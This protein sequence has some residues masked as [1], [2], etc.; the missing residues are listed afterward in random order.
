MNNITF[1]VMN[2]AREIE[3]LRD[4]QVFNYTYDQNEID[5][6]QKNFL[7]KDSLYL[8]AKHGLDFAGFCAIDRNWWEDNFFFLREI[9]INPNFR[10]LNI[11]SELMNRCIQHAKE[12]DAKGVVTETAFENHPMQELCKKYGFKEWNNPQWKNGITYKFIF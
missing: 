2:D 10:N 6:L 3:I 7:L 5:S 4:R 11:G 12:M 9:L 8:L 1:S